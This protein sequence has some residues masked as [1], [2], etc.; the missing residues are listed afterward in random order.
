VE[1][2]AYKVLAKQY[3]ISNSKAKELIDRGVVYIGDKK[4]KI[5]RGLVPLKT[6]FRVELP[7]EIEKIYEDNNLI[8]LNK[9]A[10]IDSYEIESLYNAKLIHRLDKETTGVL[11]LAKD[12]EF[13]KKAIDAFKKQEGKKE[14]SA[15]VEGMVYEEMV[16]DKPIVTLKRGGKAFSKIDKKKGKE[17]LTIVKP[18]LIHGKKSKVDIFIT[19]GRTHQIRVHLAS[20]NHPIIGDELY[21]SKVKA[22][23]ILL[24]S[25]AIELLGYRFEAKEP[26]D[27]AKYK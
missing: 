1:D 21:G 14:Y 7:Q 16:I 10:F 24:H 18:N 26:D 6:K 9:P 5:A 13:L 11:L 22:K 3:D 19:T 20:V 12:D 4:V 8:A 27:M 25:K 15:W 2:K 23:R 17:A